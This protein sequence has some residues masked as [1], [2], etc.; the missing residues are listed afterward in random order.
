[1]GSISQALFAKG[2]PDFDQVEAVTW[3]A[4]QVSIIS[5]TNFAGRILIG[6]T[7]DTVKSRLHYP[8]SFCITIVS[9]LFIL[10]QLT[11]LVVDDVQHLWMGSFL[12]GLAYGSLFGLLPTVCLEWFGLGSHALTSLFKITVL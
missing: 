10:S 5:V 6:L 3:Q 7:A 9:I 11:I 12:L 8:R 2:N 4:A 1:V